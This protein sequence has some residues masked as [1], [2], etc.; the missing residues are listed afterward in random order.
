[1][2]R[3]VS[4]GTVNA[5]PAAPVRT[6]LERAATEDVEPTVVA[7]LRQQLDRTSTFRVGP[8]GTTIGYGPDLAGAVRRL[9]E[10]DRA[11]N[12]IA[13][14]RW[15]P[16][17]KLGR[18]W[19]RASDRTWVAI[20]PDVA[21]QEPWGRVD[22]LYRSARLVSD[23][24]R[25][26]DPLT[27]F[28]SVDWQRIDGIPALAE[29]AR[30]PPGAG[31]AVLNLI[32]GV[33]VDQERRRMAYRGPY[34]TEQLFLAL[35]ESF[36]YA[37]DD[38]DPLAAFM[39]GRL[40]WVPAPFERIF[41]PGEVCVQLRGRI[42]KVTWRG[43]RYYRP[44]WQAVRRHAALRVEDAAGGA[45]CVLHALGTTLEPHL[46]I[47]REGDAVQ[48]LAPPPSGTPTPMPDWVGPGVVALAAVASA[49]PLAPLI[50]AAGEDLSFEWGPIEA[51]L[52]TIARGTVRVSSRLRSALHEQVARAGSSEARLG[53]AVLTLEDVAQVIGDTLR[54]Q[55]QA[56][57]LCLDPAARETALETPPD[58]VLE[59]RREA[60]WQ[61]VRR[62][63][64]AL[65]GEAGNN[66]RTSAR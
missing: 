7:D 31:T 65:L 22:G 21:Y 27:V 32:A 8:H 20:E 43:N 58:D 26:G 30:V 9:V 16:D 15:A 2:D 51:S 62:A 6:W 64:E 41:L 33:A 36:R 35:L 42:E 18:G 28:H 49:E 10:L 19:V 17:G 61:A 66:V 53:L 11:G 44:D 40:D 3:I 48:V 5:G 54:A 4:S 45:R 50:V 23:A 57:L 63:A 55:A 34:P 39:R 29:P 12:V 1:L 59:R 24:K 46:M 14:L 25:P 56:R 52:A 38:E 37:A 13:L 60:A 47:T